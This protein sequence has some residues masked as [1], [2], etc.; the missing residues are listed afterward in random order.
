LKYPK[1]Q[2]LNLQT[3][4]FLCKKTRNKKKKK[5]HTK[6]LTRRNKKRGPFFSLALFF[7][8]IAKGVITQKK[9]TH[10]K[11]KNKKQKKVDAVNISFS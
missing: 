10:K 9:L 6:I 5:T 11:K 2:K 3:I 1:C 8:H 4:K 7:I